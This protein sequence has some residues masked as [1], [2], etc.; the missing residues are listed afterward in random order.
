MLQAHDD[1][2]VVPRICVGMMIVVCLVILM[3]LIVSV[4]D[5]ELTNF[6]FGPIL[7][8]TSL[9]VNQSIENLTSSRYDHI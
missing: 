7:N 5:W 6:E 1:T 3:A 4:V 8:S 9:P 2:E